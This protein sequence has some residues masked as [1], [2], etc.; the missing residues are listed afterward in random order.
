MMQ[1]LAKK[2][3]SFL[4]SHF[5]VRIVRRKRRGML[6]GTRS[7]Y[8]K[9]KETA[10]AFVHHKL[11]EKNTHYALSFGKVAIRNQ[12]TRWGSC[13]KKGNLNFHY[14][15]IE[16]PEHLAD[17]LIVHELCH[18]KEFSHSKKFWSLVAETIP[19]HKARRK[20]LKR[21]T[22]KKAPP[23]PVLP[24]VHISTDQYIFRRVTT[25]VLCGVPMDLRIMSDIHL[26]FAP[27]NN[28]P[29]L[30]TDKDGILIL[31]GDVCP[32]NSRDF[33]LIPFLRAMSLRFSKVLYV[34][35][36]HEFYG[37][38]SL[39][40]GYRK[41][42]QLIRDA[43]IKNVHL[44][45][46]RTLTIGTTAFIG[47]TLWTDFDK[48]D[49]NSMLLASRRMAD[50]GEILCHTSLGE[51]RR[52]NPVDIYEAH[53][54]SRRYIFRTVKKQRALGKKTVVI[55]HHGVSTLS[56]HKRFAGDR[57]NGSFVSDLS[58]EILDTGPNLIIHGHI[59]DPVD[60]MIGNTRVVANPR[61]YPGE[62]TA[63][64]PNLI[65]QI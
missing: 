4:A 25:D 16:L 53:Q 58:E 26:E 22:F 55:V 49:P 43:K 23:E 63:W 46:D 19:D 24:K 61:G 42:R 40:L 12:R 39:T 62:N 6:A 60:Y 8:R 51:S 41:V 9:H 20:A 14:R 29:E 54:K 36:N 17:Y 27:L 33:L 18:L 57:I 44:L 30:A 1:R 7:A 5:V 10:R 28:L 2:L 11:K 47:A 52:I 56:V 32:Y 15:I 31:A 35:G 38:G 64:N 59:H 48:R 3:R 50:F 65:L 21:H 34:L 45:Q 13:S 37:Y